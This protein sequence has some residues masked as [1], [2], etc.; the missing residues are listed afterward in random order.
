MKIEKFRILLVFLLT[1][2][3]FA[4]LGI[5]SNSLDAAD[6]DPTNA[7]YVD[8]RG[9]VCIGT[10]DSL[11][12]CRLTVEGGGIYVNA[13]GHVAG[14]FKK[15]IRVI[16]SDDITG[17]LLRGD[18]TGDA[19]QILMFDTDGTRTVRIEAATTGTTGGQIWLYEAD[20]TPSLGLNGDVGGRSQVLT[21]TLEITRDGDRKLSLTGYGQGDA[22]QIL[23]FDTDGTRTVRIAAATSSTTGG[24]IWLSKADG[25]PSLGLN[26]DVGGRSEIEADRLRTTEVVTDV[27]QIQGGSDVSEHFEI[28]GRKENSLPL[29]GMVVSIDPENPGDLVVSDQAYDRRVAGIISGAGGVQPGMLMRQKRSEAD[30]KCPVALTGRVYCWADASKGSIEPGDLLTTSDTAGH[31]MKVTDYTRAQGAIL[32]KAMSRL[33]SG[34]GLVLVLITLQ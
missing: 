7:V 32:G 26:G 28:R 5:A 31:A 2:L 4:E 22:G 3:F 17:V 24:Q 14:F 12:G 25:T 30:G 8:D 18:A 20:G 19:G 11:A 9:N 23:M 15:E 29:P 27:L 33:N 13:P 6:G 21:D 10:T 16:G 34:R 1:N